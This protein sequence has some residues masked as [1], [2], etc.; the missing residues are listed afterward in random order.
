MAEPVQ[1]VRPW[2]DHSQ[3][4][5]RLYIIMRSPSVV[6]L[7]VPRLNIAVVKSG[8]VRTHIRLTFSMVELP[9]LRLPV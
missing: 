3:P 6:V 1:L 5:V 4:K 2:P 7:L 8:R 9:G